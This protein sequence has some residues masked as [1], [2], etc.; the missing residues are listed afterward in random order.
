M[1]VQLPVP[2]VSQAANFSCGSACLYACLLYW[3]GENAPYQHEPDL[4]K[5]LRIDPDAGMD[6]HGAV[7]VAQQLGLH[8]VTRMN[9]TPDHLENLLAQ[10]CTSILC[11]QAWRDPNDPSPVPYK[12]DWEDG[13]Y[14]VVVGM[15][16]ENVYFMD[17]STRTAY[18]WLSRPVFQDRW[19]SPSD[20]GDHRYGLGIIIWA[21]A[22][23][24][25]TFPAPLLP[26]G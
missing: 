10:G 16:D 26:L 15:D 18:T 5:P 8:A 17:P 23:S 12:D 13:H 11:I 25:T 7:E 14:V 22:P 1:T 3:L 4:W 2:L 9:L 19:H 20:E 6:E 21:D 24:L